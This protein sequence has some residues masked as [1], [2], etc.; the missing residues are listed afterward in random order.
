MDEGG[1]G[2]GCVEFGGEGG[3]REGSDGFVGFEFFGGTVLVVEDG[4]VVFLNT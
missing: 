1:D 2:E 3:G 4:D